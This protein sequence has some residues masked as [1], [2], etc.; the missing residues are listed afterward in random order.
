MATFSDMMSLLFVFFVLLLSFA[1]MDATK[2]RDA[3]GSVQE[4]LGVQYEHPGTISGLTT[5]IVEF[6]KKE[7][8]SNIDLVDMPAL[9]PKASDGG[10]KGQGEDM[11][12]QAIAFVKGLELGNIVEVLSSERGVTLRVRGQLLF[13]PGGAEL[14]PESLAL[15]DEVI[16]LTKAYP[17]D[18]MIEGHTDDRPVGP[19]AF[20]SNWE[21]SA[22]R[23]ISTLRYFEEVG[24]IAPERLAAAGYAGT[25]PLVPNRDAHSR[26]INRRVEFTYT[27]PPGVP[28]PELER[29]ASS[30]GGDGLEQL[31]L[32]RSAQ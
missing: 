17:Y 16:R 20:R 4:A 15:L 12:A 8:T 28:H 6:S 10:A 9:R 23:A 3:L 29:A 1:N 26:A 19:G 24:R 7:S 22:A 5:S 25:R 32:R 11:L 14:R 30:A 27:L 31:R 2:F 18:L 13:E 21:L